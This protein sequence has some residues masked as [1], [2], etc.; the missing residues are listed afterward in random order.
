MRMSIRCRRSNATDG[1][2]KN[3]R[4]YRILLSNIIFNRI[5]QHFELPQAHAGGVNSSELGKRACAMERA[6][7]EL[8][9]R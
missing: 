6:G 5:E 1:G 3:V 4:R 2:A 8:R 7:W 9:L